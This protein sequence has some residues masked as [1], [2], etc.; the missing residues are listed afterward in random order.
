MLTTSCSLLTVLLLAGHSAWLTLIRVCSKPTQC[1]KQARIDCP[2]H[3]VK[4][5][6]SILSLLYRVSF[7]D[8][9]LLHKY[10]ECWGTQSRLA[11]WLAVCLQKGKC[12]RPW[13]TIKPSFHSIAMGYWYLQLCRNLV[14]STW[15]K[16]S[17][18]RW[19]FLGTSCEGRC[20]NQTLYVL[21]MWCALYHGHSD[22]AK[23]Q[24]HACQI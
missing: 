9:L 10:F 2:P 5:T 3:V 15:T 24:I 8:L 20:S 14:L 7:Y 23:L 21:L 17:K 16:W 22:D 19:S 4:Y 13:P 11:V 6:R 1:M 12:S 18:C